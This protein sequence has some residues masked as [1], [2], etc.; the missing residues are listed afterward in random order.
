[1]FNVFNHF[2]CHD[3]AKTYIKMEEILNNGNFN[4]FEGNFSRNEEKI[5][6]L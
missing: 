2:F 1:M 3:F 5:T 6:I 4:I